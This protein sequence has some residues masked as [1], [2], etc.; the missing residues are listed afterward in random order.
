MN[1]PDA[2]GRLHSRYRP[3][4]E[5]DR[6]IQALDPGQ[7]VDFFVL[8]E[9]GMGYLVESLRRHRPNGKAVVL[10]ADAAFREFG[11]LRPGV[12]A[13]YPDCG[14]TVQEFLE[15]EIPEWASA[16]II[17]WRPSLS[18]YGEAC[19]GLVRESAEFIKR[20][21]AGR[22]TV[23]AFGR[24][25]VRNFFRNLAFMRDVLLYR[26]MDMPIVVTGSGPSL[27]ESLPGIRAARDG[28]FVLAAS[29][30]LPALAAG[31]ISPDMAIGTDGGGWALTHMHACFRPGAPP[32]LAC[33]L[34]AA[35]PSR[36]LEGPV[37]P[38]GDGS[39]WQTLA[40]GAAGVPS[41]LVPQRG[42]VTASALELALSLGT[43]GVFLAG[44]DLSV[45]DIRSHARPNGFDHLFFGTASRLRPVYSQAFVRAG[46]IRAGGSHGVYAAWFRSRLASWRGRV[47]S[48]GGGHGVFVDGPP[49]GMAGRLGDRPGDHFRAV[50]L[51][52]LP[53][54]RCRRALD[55]LVAALGDPGRAEPLA[56]ELA[57]LLFPG[58][59][60]SLA[61]DL[62]GA[63]RDVARRYHG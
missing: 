34:S 20:A 22:R 57:P 29:S 3:Q 6:Y 16:R 43:G 56:A 10:H 13:W 25:W 35:V 52:G 49:L 46:G 5:A 59:S 54:E 51:A 44:V 55:A 17:E 11:D 4:A 18:V 39:L 23:A 32:R 19:L 50:P 61:G 31:G 41:A 21:E 58:R 47:F 14:K 33:A 38:I 48:L 30:S 36:C 15:S 37:L 1:G 53:S 9:P 27:E 63:L 42:T 8:V 45:R 12:P 24:R 60:R 26:P 28:V 2:V 40:L 62:A 7:D